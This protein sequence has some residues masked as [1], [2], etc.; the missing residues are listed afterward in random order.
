[1]DRDGA[2][3]GGT[4]FASGEV[5]QA[6]SFDG[7]NDTVTVPDDPDWS[8]PGDFTI[9]TWVNFAGGF[10]GIAQALV[11]Q[12]EGSGTTN[13]WM[14]WYEGGPGA[15]G[16]EFGTGGAGFHPLSYAWSPTLSQWYHVAVTRSGSDFTLYIDGAVV[17]TGTE[18]T[19]IPDA[20][21]PL[22]LGWGETDWFFNGTAR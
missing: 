4:T 19:P 2:P 17:D 3:V 12:D 14:F 7:V 18:S 16:F 20:V 8:L 10:D 9:D 5:G 15:L 21:A 13:K 11:A 1:M 6:F 22:T